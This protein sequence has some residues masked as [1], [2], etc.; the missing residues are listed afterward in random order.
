MA[1]NALLVFLLS[2]YL[3]FASESPTAI[4]LDSDF[5]VVISS[6]DEEITL[7]V[8]SNDYSGSGYTYNVIDIQ[9]TTVDSKGNSDNNLSYQISQ[10]DDGETSYETF[11]A[12]DKTTG[13]FKYVEQYSFTET[14]SNESY[15]YYDIEFEA[16][17][18]VQA[19]DYYYDEKND[20]YV[21]ALSNTTIVNEK[22]Y[23]VYESET[24]KS[25]EYP[26]GSYEIEQES[27]FY[28]VFGS[29]SFEGSKEVETIVSSD[30]T[31]GLGEADEEF[32]WELANQVQ[33]PVDTGSF[34]YMLFAAGLIALVALTIY[35]RRT[36]INIGKS[37]AAVDERSS[38][39]IRI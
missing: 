7:A 35:K 8:S 4:N 37:L 39:Y 20:S 38:D 30:W 10:Y 19:G 34:T 31:V 16:G 26:D 36:Q 22:D 18:K 33:K 11:K 27:S 5:E 24:E 17:Q 28:G 29:L 1:T 32:E 9:E 2:L 14:K 13:D 15:Q 12:E 21:K 25:T 3:A 6:D 23:I